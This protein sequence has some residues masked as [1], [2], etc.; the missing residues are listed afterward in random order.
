MT[1]EI[2]FGNYSSSWAHE[3][4]ISGNKQQLYAEEILTLLQKGHSVW[5]GPNLNIFQSEVLDTKNGP[6]SLFF[7]SGGTSGNTKWVRHSEKSVSFAVCGLLES[8]GVEEISSWCCL[9]LN[10]VGGMMQI[11]RAIGSAGRV[12]FSS[13]RKLLD[14]VPSELIQNQ[15]I[16]L[17]PTQLNRLI[18]S[19]IACKNLRQFKG[20]F[21][22]GAALSEKLAKKARNEGIPLFPCYGM[23]ETAGMIT[24]LS[25]H[26][27]EKGIGGVGKVLPHALMAVNSLTNRISVKARSI[28]L[29]AFKEGQG[30]KEWLSTPDY[31]YHDPKGN[32][33]IEGR[34][35]RTIVTGGEKVNPHLIEKVLQEFNSV[36]ECLVCGVEDQDWGQRIVAYLTPTNLELNKL[37]EFAQERLES[38]SIPKEWKL[39]N[40][41]PL[42]EMG[43][44]KN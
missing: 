16:S 10:H 43:K 32:W 33:F 19:S 14:E 44:P 23:S 6:P 11:F 31:G 15:W 3:Q 5:L 24:L 4:N 17:V 36:D 38:H 25:S 13:Y 29:N 8:L 21:I 27:F 30:G 35:D 9:P 12:Y 42:N 20:I 1:G 40:K 26:S 37:K 41:L 22:G 18:T 7:R 2:T 39:V 28:S 34:L